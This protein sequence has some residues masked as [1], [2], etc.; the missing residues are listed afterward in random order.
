MFSSADL[1]NM[2]F[3]QK[4]VT[5]QSKDVAKASKKR[6]FRTQVDSLSSEEALVIQYKKRVQTT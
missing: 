2:L 1:G 6:G 5:V 3:L 4:L